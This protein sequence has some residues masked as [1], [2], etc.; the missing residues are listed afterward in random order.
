M[1]F[2]VLLDVE[3]TIQHR[4]KERAIER[5]REV[6]DGHKSKVVRVDEKSNLSEVD[7]IMDGLEVCLSFDFRQM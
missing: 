1:E 4:R 5:T 7:H 2:Q 6:H 3:A